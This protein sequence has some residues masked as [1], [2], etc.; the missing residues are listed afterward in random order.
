[1]A[2]TEKQGDQKPASEDLNEAKRRIASE[3]MEE[4]K[5]KY[6]YKDFSYWNGLEKGIELGANWQKEQMVKQSVDGKVIAKFP[7]ASDPF[8]NDVEIYLNFTIGLSEGDKVKV[9]I[10]KDE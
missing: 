7:L 4:M 3:Y 5:E 1:M 10:I 9:I 8:Y 6:G 2:K